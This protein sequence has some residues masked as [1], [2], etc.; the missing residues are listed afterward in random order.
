MNI[1]KEYLIATNAK[2]D[3]RALSKLDMVRSMGLI[4]ESE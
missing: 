3:V 1:M 2:Q 4:G